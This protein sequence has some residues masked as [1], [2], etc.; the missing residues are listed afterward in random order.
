MYSL[1]IRRR[2]TRLTAVVGGLVSS[3]GLLFTSFASEYHQVFLSY[4]LLLGKDKL[5]NVAKIS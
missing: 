3:L 4:G 1:T 5:R 2:S